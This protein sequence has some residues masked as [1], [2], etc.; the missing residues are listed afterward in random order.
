MNKPNEKKIINDI[1]LGKKNEIQA[2]EQLQ[3][4]PLPKSNEDLNLTSP[5]NPKEYV[6]IIGRQENALNNSPAQKNA[7]LTTH[8]YRKDGEHRDHAE[9]TLKTE[10]IEPTLVTHE[11]DH[12][13]HIAV[14]A[15]NA[16]TNL[17]RQ[18]LK[19]GA[20]LPKTAKDDVSHATKH[21]NHQEDQRYDEQELHQMVLKI[22][23]HAENT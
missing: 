19:R 5:R 9:D 14:K 12:T 2:T 18:S 16:L 7:L 17:E 8:H 3:H 6:T 21:L 20:T 11:L 4:L 22:D 23:H 13:V 15:R 1:R 10:K